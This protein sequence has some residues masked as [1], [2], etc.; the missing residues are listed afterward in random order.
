[1]RRYSEKVGAA[2]PLWKILSH[3]PHIGFE[4]KRRALRRMSRLLAL[5]EMLRDMAQFLANER[6]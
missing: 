5:Q 4:Y 2:L 6:D 1:L 3:H